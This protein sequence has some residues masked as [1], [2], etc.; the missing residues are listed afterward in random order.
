MA[1][2]RMRRIPI[3]SHPNRLGGVPTPNLFHELADLVRALVLVERP[4]SAA[5]IHF[6]DGKQIEP[7]PG[8]LPAL[9]NQLRGGRVAPAAIS[10]HRNEWLIQKQQHAISR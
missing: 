3:Q 2:S 7:P 4:P 5:R 10:F 9:E 6:V 8:L 1:F